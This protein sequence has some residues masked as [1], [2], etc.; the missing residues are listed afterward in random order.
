MVYV[1]LPALIPDIREIYDV[2]F[3]AF[4]NDLMG[5]LMLN[6]L[7][8][9]ISVEAEEFRKSHT[10]GAV[11]YLHKSTVQYSFK[12]VD[13]AT[14]TIVGVALGDIYFKERTEEERKFEGVLWLHGKER[15]RAEKV[16][17]PLWEARERLFGGHPH[18]C[19]HWEQLIPPWA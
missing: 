13:T 19:K 16:V 17:R 2:Y 18:I 10:E 15:E 11:A 6:V 1:V 3:A 4:R 8:P 14:G 9:G 5:R 12:C 7:F